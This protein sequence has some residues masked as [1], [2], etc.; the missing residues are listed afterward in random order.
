MGSENGS[1]GDFSAEDLSLQELLAI[2]VRAE[3]EAAETYREL[4]KKD[5]SEE[6]RN[7]L[8]DLVSQEES[9]EEEFW[10]ILEDFYPEE[11]IS[12][13]ENS[14]ITNPVEISDKTSLD[15]LF[16]AAMESEVKSEEFYK[17]MQEKFEDK[18][19]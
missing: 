19:V 17:L 6:T 13:P 2:A 11:E 18:E 8:E 5:L 9:H 16:R 14:G 4:L 12:L 10:S 7:K 1:I 15:E 3:I